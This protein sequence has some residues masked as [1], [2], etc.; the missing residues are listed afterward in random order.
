MNWCVRRYLAASRLHANNNCTP[1]LPAAS[2]WAGRF[3]EATETARRGLTYLH[4]EVSPHRARLFAI[5]AQALAAAGVYQPADE[6]LREALHIAS[7]LSDPK[8]AA[9]LLGVRSI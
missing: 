7:Q 2:I 3:Q 6:A 5:L 4:G 8:L 1:E 9:R